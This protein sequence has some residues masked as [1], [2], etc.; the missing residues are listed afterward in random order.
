MTEVKLLDG[1]EST[2]LATHVDE[3]ID[4]H[5][6]WTSRFLCTNPDAVYQMHLDFLR[7]GSNIFKTNT[8]QASVPG[9]IK[10]LDK[11][12]KE[13]L[14]LIKT[15]VDLAKKAV[16]AYK[17]EIKS[18]KVSNPE[19]LVAGSVGPYAA[20][21]NDGS[22]YTGGSYENLESI[23]LVVEWHKPRI[24]ALIDSGVD[25]LAIETIPCAREA[26]AL[27]EFLVK[28]YPGKISNWCIC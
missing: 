17:D 21:L 18:I 4:G 20:S 8:Y 6:L 16:R 19:P 13:S 3:I 23:D 26:K 25:L 11:S 15:A 24:E 12:E 10:Y 5:P 7:A 1:G 14:Q 28:N 22:E 27:V 2:Q 9:F